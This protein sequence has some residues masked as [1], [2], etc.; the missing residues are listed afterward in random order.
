MTA[1]G[2]HL[3]PEGIFVQLADPPPVGTMVRVTVAASGIEGSLSAD[4]E[5]VYQ[6]FEDDRQHG[7]TGCGVHVRSKGP[8]WLRL[9][10]WLSGSPE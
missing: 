1:L 8:A 6:L 4:G 2:T 3:N 5:V 10:E 7:P 9:Y